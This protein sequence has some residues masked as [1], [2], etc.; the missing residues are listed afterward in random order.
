MCGAL[1]Q[2]GALHVPLMRLSLLQL[3][4]IR[5]AASSGEML[6][7]GPEQSSEPSENDASKELVNRRNLSLDCICCLSYE[8]RT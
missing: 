5:E 3:E 8:A 6:S 2:A 1:Y 7:D 4:L